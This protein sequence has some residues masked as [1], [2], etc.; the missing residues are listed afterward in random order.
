MNALRKYTKVNVDDCLGLCV[1]KVLRLLLY[2]EG[3][4]MF[5][6]SGAVILYILN[7]AKVSQLLEIKIYI[8]LANARL[9]LLFKSLTFYANLY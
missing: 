4:L 5:D 6:S 3:R 8:L 9:F 1:S 7:V 2:Y